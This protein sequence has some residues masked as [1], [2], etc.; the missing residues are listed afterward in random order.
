MAA[1]CRASSRHPSPRREMASFKATLRIWNGEV[2]S[3]RARSKAATL[4]AGSRAAHCSS[5][6]RPGAKSFK[7]PA[8]SITASESGGQYIRNSQAG[9]GFLDA[10]RTGPYTAHRL[11]RKD[12]RLDFEPHD[13]YL[14]RVKKLSEIVEKGHVAYP[15]RF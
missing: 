6:L 11:S 7:R 5:T 8:K 2:Q 1:C 9:R 12:L 13:Q 10:P 4:F 3:C 15:T 14:Q